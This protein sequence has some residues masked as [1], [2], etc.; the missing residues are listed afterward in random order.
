ML[1]QLPGSAFSIRQPDLSGHSKWHVRPAHNN[2]EAYID[3]L[4]IHGLQDKPKAEKKTKA[5]AKPKETK[6]DKPEAE[7][8]PRGRPP[9]AK[10]ADKAE[11]E[12]A[13]KVAML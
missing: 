8:K 9:K 11:E 10:A 1:A 5:A 6:E 2:A 7:K 4:T 13:D 3:C 12:P